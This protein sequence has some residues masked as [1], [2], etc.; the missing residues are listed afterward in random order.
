MSGAFGGK[1]RYNRSSPSSYK[2]C[3]ARIVADYIT[4]VVGRP[5]RILDVG[6]TQWGF[7]ANA[8]LPPGCDIVIVNP[9]ADTG[10]Q[11]DDVMKI[12]G[13]A[14]P[15]DFAMMFG[16]MMYMTE[17]ELVDQFSKIRQR[18]RGEYTFLVA[19]PNPLRLVG[20]IEAIARLVLGVTGILP[21]TLR[22][23]TVGQARSMLHDAGFREFRN[24]DDLVP[25]LLG[26]AI[27]PM[28]Y[29]IAASV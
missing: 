12:P 11:Y 21:T 2:D 3:V 28:Y 14:Q 17:S 26:F 13:D 4:P 16:V 6:G 24:R 5:A 9:E 27:D 25:K 8:S 10:A 15:F 20:G 1:A 19:E 23:Y 29:V 18:M 7:K 22:P